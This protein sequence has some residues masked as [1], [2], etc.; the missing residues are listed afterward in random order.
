MTAIVDPNNYTM[1]LAAAQISQVTYPRYSCPNDVVPGTYNASFNF[2]IY[3]N[4][5]LG[6]QDLAP[7]IAYSI[8]DCLD[9]CLSYNL[10]P[11]KVNGTQCVGWSMALSVAFFAIH[12]V[13]ANCFLKNTPLPGMSTVSHSQ[14]FGPVWSG[15]L[16]KD[17]ACHE[18]YAGQ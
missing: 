5:T 1:P 6:G 16:C 7:I 4:T 13:N 15:V 18:I 17:S 8:N 11:N 14:I 3:C 10:N 2:K 12:P 9:A